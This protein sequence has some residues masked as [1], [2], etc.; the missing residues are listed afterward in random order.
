LKT[1][2]LRYL[3][4]PFTNVDVIGMLMQNRSPNPIGGY[5]IHNFKIKM[6]DVCHSDAER[7][8]NVKDSSI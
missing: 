5:K 6:V 2:K 8:A 1:V 4:K 7:V 3:H